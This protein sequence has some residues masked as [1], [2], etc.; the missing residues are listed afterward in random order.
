[1]AFSPPAVVAQD[2]ADP[3]A[4]YTH[5]PALDGLRGVAV[6]AVL[7]YHGAQLTGSPLDVMPGGFLGVDL[8]MV[9]SGFLI[10]TLLWREWNHTGAI[11]LAAFYGRRARRLLPALL[12]V[13]AAV[14]V[15]VLFYDFF[16]LDETQRGNFPGDA[17][18]SLLHVANWRFVFS[19]GSYF[20]QFAG[21]SPLRHLWSLAIEEQFYL[22]WPILLVGML[23]LFRASRTAIMC[24]IGA[25][26][27]ASAGLMAVL[28]AQGAD[29]S[30]IYY[31]TD[32]RSQALLVGALLAVVVSSWD[33][34][35]LGRRW[36]QVAAWLSFALYL[37]MVLVVNDDANDYPWMYSGGFLLIAALGGF[38]VLGAAGVGKSAYRSMLSVGPLVFF[39]TIS[40][41]L[42]LWHWPVYVMLTTETTGYSGITLLA[43]RVTISVGLAMASYVVVERPI[44]LGALRT[45]WGWGIGA[46]AGAA[47]V[48]LVASTVFVRPPDLMADVQLAAED[49]QQLTGGVGPRVLV[50]GDSVAFSLIPGVRSAPSLSVRN[51]AIIGCGVVRGKVLSAGREIPVPNDCDVWPSVWQQA[52]SAFDPELSVMLIGAW[53]VLDHE[54]DGRVLRVGSDE[55]ADYMLEELE[56]TREVLTGQ[57][58]PMAI[59][60]IPCRDPDAT[61]ELRPERRESWRV[62]W[63]NSVLKQFADRHPDV[64]VIDLNGALCPNGEYTGE[65][66][67]TPLFR[68]SVHFT[69]EGAGATWEWLEPRLLPLV[70]RG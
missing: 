30:R 2:G 33:E 46:V 35:A 24:V 70:G 62:P 34:V 50:V 56:A 19:G 66:N 58:A 64:T 26:I 21:P 49:T 45:S 32:T 17:A 3:Q 8:F 13:L 6:L 52:M 31:G 54:V 36:I 20:D 44:R 40:Y 60:S 65:L 38:C 14:A 47:V 48:L 61:E 63:V 23:R 59:L 9:L 5:K 28:F 16:R 25:G 55:Y 51:G 29:I 43:L 42:Y 22:L 11:R 69:T 41:G 12:L 10:T 67:G 39:G 68:D 53:E 18:S 7:V 27:A 57:G 1:M 4:A 37:A 15:A